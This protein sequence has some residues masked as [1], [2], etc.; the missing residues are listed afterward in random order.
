MDDFA[1][2]KS[3]LFVPGSP[4]NEVVKIKCRVFLMFS[5]PDRLQGWPGGL[6]K[7]TGKIK[8]SAG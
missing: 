1:M 8:T 2:I 6:A 4:P 7:Q 3:I 5:K